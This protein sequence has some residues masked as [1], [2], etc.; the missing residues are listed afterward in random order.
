LSITL[1]PRDN[2]LDRTSQR[3][4]TNEDQVQI[5]LPLFEQIN[6]FVDSSIKA[7]LC[8]AAAPVWPMNAIDSMRIIDV[9]VVWLGKLPNVAT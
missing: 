5:V 6:L 7:N 3:R 4:K 2:G 8:S 9:S 1:Q